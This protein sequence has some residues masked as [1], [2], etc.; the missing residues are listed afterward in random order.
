MELSLTN[1]CSFYMSPPKSECP[2]H[3]AG[4]RTGAAVP[5][6]PADQMAAEQSDSPAPLPALSSWRLRV[7]KTNPRHI[8][9]AATEHGSLW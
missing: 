1:M 2:V 4:G 8:L 9:S 5:A 6:D 7:E 3:K